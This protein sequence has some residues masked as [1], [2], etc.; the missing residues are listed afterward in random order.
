VPH[1]DPLSAR[2]IGERLRGIGL[3]LATAAMF[4]GVDSSS[5]F[6][7]RAGVPTLEVVWARYAIS[8]LVAVA[9]LRPWRNPAEY[10]T[11]RPISQAVRA[12]LLLMST[13]LN[14]IA[15]QHL[16]LS[17]S[18]AINFV[19]PLIV[20]AL[21]GPVLGEWAGW[22]RWAAVAVGF[23]GVL[24]VIQPT[25]SSFNPAVI[26]SLANAVSFAGYALATRKLSV[27]ETPSSMLIY[28]SL[29]ATVVLLPALPATHLAIPSW[30]AALA[31]VICGGCGA[32][33]HLFVIHAYRHAPAMVV[34]P[35]S[36]SQL[37]WMSLVGYVVFA[38]LPTGAT[39][40][41]A[42]VIV[43]S[44]LYILYRQQVHRDRR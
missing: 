4:A 9:I 10:V 44:G 28:A 3:M 25:P 32:F 31:M 7:T 12:L 20:T 2:E 22:H 6:A 11:R 1:S 33:G 30:Q 40:I 14:F 15:V 17:E 8:L 27:T 18:A 13:T 26:A 36:Y 19:S 21:A 41:G 42:A 37:L 5:K 43:A 35:F 24:I 38:D 29:V 34:A 39:L 23:A 16:Q